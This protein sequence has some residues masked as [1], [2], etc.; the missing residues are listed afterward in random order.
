VQVEHSLELLVG[1]TYKKDTRS[2]CQLC[3]SML[4][5]EIQHALNLRKTASI[6]EIRSRPVGAIDVLTTTN[7]CSD[8]VHASA[9]YYRKHEK[10]GYS[11]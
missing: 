8:I 9:I 4:T 1:R 6:R 5:A 2:R 3:Y 7:T 10:V 11:L